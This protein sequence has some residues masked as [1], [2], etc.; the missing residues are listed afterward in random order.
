MIGWRGAVPAAVLGLAVAACSGDDQASQPRPQVAAPARAHETMVLWRARTSTATSPK[1]RYEIA[2][3]DAATRRPRALAP[4]LGGE[5]QPLLFDRPTWSPDG[6]HIA[7]SVE[8]DG[9]PAAPYRTDIYVMD[10]NGSGVRR[11]TRSETAFFPVWSP[12]GRTIAFAKRASSRPLSVRELLSTTVWTIGTDGNDERELVPSSSVTADTPGAW[13]PDAE[14]LA[15]TRRTY[16]DPEQSFESSRAIY[17]V[18]ADGSGLLKLIEHGSDPAWSPDGR[19]IAYVSD[20]DRN[21]ELSYGDQTSFANELYVAKADGSEPKRLTRT[22]DLNERN[23]AWSP[24]GT[25]IAYTRGEQFQNAEATSV[26]VVEADGA[27]P[28]EIAA[29][30]PDG[31]WYANAVWRPGESRSQLTPTCP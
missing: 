18:A 25:R 17:I 12:D 6:G 21:G 5:A 22:R 29:E 15:F 2:A 19:L 13:S 24:D 28:T 1:A 20:R 9:D 31:A 10:A 4:R 16:V 11:L 14:S 8:L 7:F 26:L 30:A 27:C 3:I 23:P